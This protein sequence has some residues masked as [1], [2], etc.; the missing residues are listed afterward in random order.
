MALSTLSAELVT[1]MLR[2]LLEWESPL[3]NYYNSPLYDLVH[4]YR[5]RLATRVQLTH[6]RWSDIYNHSPY[7]ANHIHILPLSGALEDAFRAAAKRLNRSTCQSFDLSIRLPDPPSHCEQL[8]LDDLCRSFASHSSLE[9]CASLFLDGLCSQDLVVSTLAPAIRLLRIH[10]GSHIPYHPLNLLTMHRLESLHI[11]MGKQSILAV[12]LPP[13]LRD[14]RVVANSVVLGVVIDALEMLEFLTHLELEVETDAV[15]YYDAS[16][17]KPSF[18]FAL[19]TLVLRQTHFF[20]ESHVLALGS[21]ETLVHLVLETALSE[22]WVQFVES[23]QRLATLSIL[24]DDHNDDYPSQAFLNGDYMNE[25]YLLMNPE[26]FVD[27]LFSSATVTSLTTAL[28]PHFQG[29]VRF[30]CLSSLRV[31]GELRIAIGEGRLVRHDHLLAI[32]LPMD[33]FHVR[34]PRVF[35]GLHPGIEFLEIRVVD[36]LLS[37][38]EPDLSF[39]EDSAAFLPMLRLLRIQLGTCRLQHIYLPGLERMVI[40]IQRQRP[41]LCIEWM[42]NGSSPLAAPHKPSFSFPVRHPVF[43]T[44]FDDLVAQKG[45]TMRTCL[46]YYLSPEE[47]ERL[48]LV[49][50]PSLKEIPALDHTDC[51]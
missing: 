23:C 18:S 9:R 2:C 15:V 27:Q 22:D 37:G 43:F 44:S 47:D 36:G 6:S 10:F 40:K 30:P 25:E 17:E 45:S 29:H 42:S 49:W 26:Y 46:P 33:G 31:E 35:L 21:A 20:L 38:P 32:S 13:K 41:S 24:P 1:E 7:L 50:N 48:G 28:F 3:C 8:L 14:L 39:L 51:S 34:T 4:A 5:T 16:D 12:V 19:E 11:R